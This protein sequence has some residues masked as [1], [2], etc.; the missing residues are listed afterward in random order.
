[1]ILVQLRTRKKWLKAAAVL[2]FSQFCFLTGT[3]QAQAE[4]T[5]PSQPAV[6]TTVPAPVEAVEVQPVEEAVPAVE[7]PAEPMPETDAPTTN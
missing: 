5:T 7:T 4:E 6:E 2:A 1:M 3:F